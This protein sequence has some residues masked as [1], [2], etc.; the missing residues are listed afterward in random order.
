VVGPPGTAERVTAAMEVLFPGSSRVA[1]R[2]ATDLVDLV[3]GVATPIGPLTVTA[4]PVVHAS[5]APSLALRVDW[6]GRVVAYS[7][8]TEWCPTLTRRRPGLVQTL[9]RLTVA[10]PCSPFSP[11]RARQ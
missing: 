6:A 11:A 4:F 7:G 10:I 8:D 3:P 1:R 5:G 9:R 2:F